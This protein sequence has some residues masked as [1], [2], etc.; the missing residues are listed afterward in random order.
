MVDLWFEA[1]LCRVVSARNPGVVPTAAIEGRLA[2]R[3]QAKRGGYKKP[4]RSR[5]GEISEIDGPLLDAIY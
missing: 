5:E 1:K 4:K 2:G 3:G